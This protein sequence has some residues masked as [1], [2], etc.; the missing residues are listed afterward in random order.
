M[1]L[2]RRLVI[3]RPLHVVGLVWFGQLISLVG[4]GL[5][6]FAVGV[7]VYRV[8]GSTTEYA[9]LSFSFFLP[10]VVL[11]PIAGALVDRWDRRRA[12]LLS[13]VG[14][15]LAT[16]VLWLLVLGSQAQLW[17]FRSWH[18][19]LPIALGSA[20]GALRWPAYLASMTLLVP[21]QHLGRVNGLMELANGVGQITAPVLAGVLI[22]Y[23]GLQG[24]LL[25]DIVSF[26]FVALTLLIVRFPPNP[27]RETTGA[28]GNRTLWQDVIYG[29]RFIVTQPGLSGL[30]LFLASFNLVMSLVTVL[31]TP[32]VLSFAEVSSLG[33]ILSVSGLGMLAGALVMSVRGESQ[34]KVRDLVVLGFM[35]GLLLLTTGLPP[36]VIR[37]AVGGA[38]FLFTAPL[39]YSSIQTIFQKKVAPG[40]QGRV[41]A[42]RQM[43]GLSSPLIATSLAGPLADRLF[44][45][46]MAP[47]GALADSVGRLIGTGA[48][49]GIGLLFI[50]LGVV[51]MLSALAVYLSPRVWNVEA[52]LA[53]AIDGGGHPHVAT[54]VAGESPR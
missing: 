54:H 16:C 34:R 36:H 44:E 24:V 50:I 35:A 9:L 46:W 31:L 4:S 21:K 47:G 22:G 28:A 33:M 41:F 6:T 2:L 19:Y 39:I 26:G 20:F 49:R 40:L 18:F 38:F 53:D 29:C 17:P 37:I 10:L 5:T 3:V 25:I 30:M 48:G 11:S 1:S 45:P 7:E 14:A 52:E 43:I 23:I 15:G 27:G 51:S 12:M 32:L 8:T 13:E 42:V